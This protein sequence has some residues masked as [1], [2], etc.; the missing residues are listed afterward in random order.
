MRPARNDSCDAARQALGGKLI[1]GEAVCAARRDIFDAELWPSLAA[2]GG[3]GNADPQNEGMSL[4]YAVPRPPS[5]ARPRGLLSALPSQKGPSH[6]LMAACFETDSNRG[7]VQRVLRRCSRCRTTV[8]CGS[9]SHHTAMSRHE[10]MRPPSAGSRSGSLVVSEKQFSRAG[11]SAYRRI[12]AAIVR[13]S[14]AR[15]PACH[16]P[17]RCS[18]LI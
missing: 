13:Q 9:P 15:A 11:L 12:P 7:R 2:A 3:N 17:S 14:P 6:L 4:L 16:G 1:G 8:V 18:A 5:Y 10:I